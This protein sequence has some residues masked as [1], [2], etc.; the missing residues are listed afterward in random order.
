MRKPTIVSIYSSLTISMIAVNRTA[1]GIHWNLMMI[2]TKAVTL[3][4]AIGK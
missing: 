4:I 2:Y 1:S 3:G